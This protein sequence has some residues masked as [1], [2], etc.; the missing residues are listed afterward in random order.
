MDKV[1]VTIMDYVTGDAIGVTS[2]A[3]EDRDQIAAGT[4]PAYQWPE[5][6][7]AAGDIL[8]EQEIAELEIS[9]G[10]VIWLSI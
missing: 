7:A 8:T 10:S 3:T 6:I 5:G 4:H 9:R 1:T 2:I